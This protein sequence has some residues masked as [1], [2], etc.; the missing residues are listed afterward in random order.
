M[1][2]PQAPPCPQYL[3]TPPQPKTSCAGLAGGS[4]GKPLLPAD[5]QRLCQGR[6]HHR[7][8]TLGP[9]C[10]PHPG[11][12]PCSDYAP[13]QPLPA[14]SQPSPSPCSS[15]KQWH[16]PWPPL[17]LWGPVPVSPQPLILH[18]Q[19]GV[20]SQVV[21]TW[22]QARAA[23]GEPLGQL[24]GSRGPGRDHRAGVGRGGARGEGAGPPPCC[25]VGRACICTWQDW[26]ELFKADSG[27]QLL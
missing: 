14:P 19:S 24:R 17:L 2:P 4:L 8:P 18:L 21:A 22:N 11:L 23:L 10:F 9:S 12:R 13:F 26:V 15:G 3:S 25:V 27:H 5:S 16:W 7:T 1:P 6:G 20:S